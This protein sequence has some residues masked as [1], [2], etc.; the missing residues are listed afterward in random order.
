MI[1]RLANVL[2]TT[3]NWLL[4]FDNVEDEELTEEELEIL[5]LFRSKSP[6]RY[7]DILEI[8]RRV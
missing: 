2:H 5:R 1:I 7:D 6:E 3:P 4:G 8:M